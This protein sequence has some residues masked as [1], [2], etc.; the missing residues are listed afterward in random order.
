M[1]PA[2]Q[3]SIDHFLDAIWLELGLSPNTLQAYRRDLSLYS[4]WLGERALDSTGEAELNAYFAARHGQTKAST[5]NRR[6]TV[7]RRYFRWALRERLVPDGRL[8]GTANLLIHPTLDAANIAF[9]LVAASSEGLMVGPILLGMSKPVHVL[10][11]NVTARGVTNLT[12]IAA[13]QSALDQGA[14]S[15]SPMSADVLRTF[16]PAQA[17]KR[18]KL[19][20]F[21]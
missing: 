14:P 8:T 4:Q 19:W 5:A 21:S 9:S 18:M 13:A 15:P 6:L 3:A 2:S 7:L 1:N 11:P 10:T 20:P 16:G 17:R 12:A